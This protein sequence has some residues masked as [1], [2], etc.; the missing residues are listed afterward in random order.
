MYYNAG[1]VA[2]I[3]RSINAQQF[4]SKAESFPAAYYQ[5]N[6][7]NCKHSTF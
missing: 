6:A 1:G 4:I 5:R 7:N 2:I 3:L